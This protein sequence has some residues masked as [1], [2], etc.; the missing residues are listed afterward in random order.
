MAL[1]FVTTSNELQPLELAV[2]PVGW[3]SLRFLFQ[4]DP[5]FNGVMLT[6]SA[7]LTFWKTGGAYLRTL[8]EGG[9]VAGGQVIPAGGIDAVCAVNVFERDPNEFRNALALRQQVDFTTYRSSA[10]GV[11]VKLKEI[12]FATSVLARADSEVDLFGSTSL[13]GGFLAPPTPVSVRMHSQM[14]RLKYEA[15]QKAAT[16]LSPGLMFGDGEDPS[17]EQLLY[18]GFDTKGDNDLGIESFGGGFVAGSAISVS[19]LLPIDFN[20]KLTV[21]LDLRARVEAHNNGDGPEFETVEG[22][23]Y[24][25]LIRRDGSVIAHKLVPD[26]YEGGLGGDYISDFRTGAQN[27]T[28]DVESGDSLQLYARYFVH[29]IGGFGTQQFRYRTNITAQMQP[30]SY[31]RITAESTTRETN[32]VAQAPRGSHDRWRRV[33]FRIFRAHR[34]PPGVRRGWP[35]LA[36]VSH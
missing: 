29:D 31:L 11:E 6:G 16:D 4:R 26:F 35:W 13:G 34:H 10:Q 15:T 3:N 18:F 30:G 20:G 9:V 32:C 2:A 14:L 17:H 7:S 12:G 36:P 1:R 8:Y 27:Y 25:R 5:Q 23:A 24:L 33:L 28:F 19:P 21:A 22:D